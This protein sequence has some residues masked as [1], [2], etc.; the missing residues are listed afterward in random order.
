MHLHQSIFVWLARCAS[1]TRSQEIELHVA[2]SRQDSIAAGCRRC[3]REHS[4]RRVR[5]A[6]LGRI[7][8]AE[9][10]LESWYEDGRDAVLNDALWRRHVAA[11]LA[12][13]RHDLSGIA[14]LEA[15]VA[16][17]RRL[18]LVASLLWTRLDLAAALQTR[19]SRR[20]AEEFRQA[21]E[22]AAAVGAS[23][24]QQMA[25]LG[26]RRLGVRTWRRGQA[27]RG[28]RPLDTLSE[29]ER[30]IAALIRE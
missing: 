20:A 11:L 10:Q 13:A 14:E 23:T 7:E 24:E 25:D 28:E 1:Q 8:E 21:G 29:R 22:L 6:R 17:R 27:K 2:A 26:L 12:V 30:Q 9:G 19:D 3:S 16:E 5:P 15:L 4:S 18:G